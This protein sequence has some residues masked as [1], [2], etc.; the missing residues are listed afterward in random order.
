[1]FIATATNRMTHL[2][3]SEMFLQGGSSETAIRSNGAAG[4]VWTNI[5]KHCVP[6]G[7][8]VVTNLAQNKK[9]ALG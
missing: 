1:M 7:L 3:R 8:L 2:R 4:T 6:T 5:C 9:L